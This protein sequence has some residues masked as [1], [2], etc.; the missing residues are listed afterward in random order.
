[1]RDAIGWFAHHRVAANLLMV[2]IVAGGLLT[3]PTITREV[4]P[5][6]TPDL[7]SVRVAYP[8]ASPDEVESSVV[9]RI[10]ERLEGLVGIRRIT[11]TASEGSALVVAELFTDA[12]PQR[13]LEDIKTRI[14]AITS[15]PEEAEEPV[16]ERPIIRR[17]VINVAVSGSVGERELKETAERVRDDIAALPGISN[18]EVSGVR[19][20]EISIEISEDAL[21]RHRLTFD[22][23]ADAVRRASIDLPGGVLKTGGGEIRLRTFGQARSRAEFEQLALLSRAD[24]T[25]LALGDVARVRDGFEERDRRM[26]FDGEPAALVRVFRVGDQ[27]ALAVSSAVADY[28]ESARASLPAGVSLTTWDDDARVLRG[29]IDTL[30]RNARSGLLLVLVALALFLKPRLAFW[31]SAGIPVSFLGALWVMPSADVSLNVVS[32]FAFILVLGI[33][34]DDSI[35]VGENVY[36]RQR[37]RGARMLEAAIEGTREVAVPVTFGVLTTV[38]A[39]CPLL[40]VQGAAGEIWRQIPVVV[41]AALLFSLVKCYLV[42]PAHLGHPGRLRFQAPRGLAGLGRLPDRVG[43]GLERFVQ[44]HYRPVLERVLRGRYAMLAASTALVMICI[45]A[46]VGGHVRT[47]FFPPVEGDQVVASFEL[48]PG[49]PFEVTRDVVRRLETAASRLRAR[50][51]QEPGNAKAVEHVLASAGEQ[52]GRGRGPDALQG[53]A[54][55]NRGSVVVALSSAE[56]REITTAEFA[57]RW[58]EATGTIP[59]V[60]ELTFSSDL[61]S[62]GDAIDIE[63][64]GTDVARLRDVATGVRRELE[65]YPGVRDVRDSY[66]SAKDELEL[67]LRPE[68][69]GLGLSVADLARQVRQAFYGEEAQRLARGGEDVKVMVRY[70]PEGRRALGDVENLRIR[71]PQ[72][73]AV[74]LSVVADARMAEGPAAIRRADGARVVNVRADVDIGVT[75]AQQ[76]LADLRAGPL[77]ALL[78]DANGV[79]YAL[80]GEQ[81]E[82]RESLAGLGRGF[83]FALLGIFILLAVPLRS[84]AQ[85]LLVMSTIPLGAVG[86]VT[87]HAVLGLPIS[88]SSVIGMV[89]LAGVVVN[90]SLVLVD[91]ANRRRQ[92]GPDVRAAVVEAGLSRF[93][94][95]FLTSLTTCLGLTPL[96]LEQSVQAQFLIPMAVS[97]AAGVVAATVVSLLVVPAAYLVLEDLR[98]L[99][100]RSPVEARARA[101]NA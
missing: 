4:F 65:A 37:Q 44:R 11:S 57:R 43:A 18:V 79:T 29:R 38:V 16:V 19:A 97:I 5:D 78:R 10:E 70:P 58:R 39:F 31:V 15:F 52:L 8:G 36:T 86:A 3:L 26:R 81:R 60:D 55:S 48:P 87:G 50:V 64:R 28:V 83:L 94:P 92:H 93:R 59:G 101:A 68:A 42:L 25:R 27:S 96:L 88:F 72:G 91:W 47:T 45:S 2:A 9:E 51:E 66:R 63:L 69:E 49:T 71:T 30:A 62:A 76:V 32:L 22:D 6:I 1:M 84:Y 67:R 74:P 13:T 90:D 12:D 82:Q 73:D 46:L 80:E 56:G 99:F 7:V 98:R 20:D 33:L 17:Q 54:G 75:S 89:A 21:R 53:S 35:V 77:P 23:V 85:P 95:V 100:E 14:D 61:F 41:I 24:G 40:F 34:V